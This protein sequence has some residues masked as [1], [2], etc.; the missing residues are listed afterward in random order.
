MASEGASEAPAEQAQTAPV[1]KLYAQDFEWGKTIGEGAY[2]E[3][4]LATAIET[5][6]TY[7]IKVF[8]SASIFGYSPS[9]RLVH[10]KVVNKKHV[11]QQKKVEWVNREKTLLD[12]LRHPNIVNLFYT[13]SSPENLHFVMEY[14]CVRSP[15]YK[16]LNLTRGV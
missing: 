10:V 2:G 8:L 3:V 13:F 5:G 12:K 9:Y 4:K 14:W 15:I 1:K 16:L 7:A 11:I 6:V